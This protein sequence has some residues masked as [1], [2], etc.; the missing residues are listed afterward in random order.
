MCQHTALPPDAEADR[1]WPGGVC[2]LL[3]PL[4]AVQID[5]KETVTCRMSDID[6]ITA[7]EDDFPAGQ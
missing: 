7:G 6:Q 5:V 1:R 3:T 2:Q 4:K